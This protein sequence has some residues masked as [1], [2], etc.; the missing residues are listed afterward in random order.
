MTPYIKS[1][2]FR[3]ILDDCSN[4]NSGNWEFGWKEF[5]KRYKLYIYKHVTRTEYVLPFVQWASLKCKKANTLL[6]LLRLKMCAFDAAIV[7]QSVLQLASPTARCRWKNAHPYKRN[8]T[9]P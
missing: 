5:I 9:F 3:Q 7:W 2:P 4:T 1:I 8:Y 6:L